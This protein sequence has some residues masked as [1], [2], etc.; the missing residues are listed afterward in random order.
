MAVAEAVGPRRLDLTRRAPILALA[1]SAGV[2]IALAPWLGWSSFA[3]AAVVLVQA[4]IFTAILQHQV[5]RH[6]AT[7]RML[8]SLVG[9]LLS[10]IGLSLSTHS[11]MAASIA[12]G[13]C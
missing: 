11:T 13:C 5:S 6:A 3:L 9:G 10:L 2:A 7:F 1:S 4:V 8:P 12:Q